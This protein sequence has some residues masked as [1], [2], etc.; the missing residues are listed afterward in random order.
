MRTATSMILACLL[1]TGCSMTARSV[2]DEGAH[3][4]SDETIAQQRQ[5]LAANTAGRGFGPQSPRDIDA[6]SGSNEIAFEAAPPPSRMN[7]C[8]IHFHQN[9]EHRGGEF[10]LY[11]GNGDGH[12]YGSGY[13]YSGTLT[14][15]ELQPTG[16]D[17]CP[18]KHGA[19]HP[20]DTIEAHYVYSSAY[21]RPGPSL[22]S[23]MSDSIHNPQLR[24]EAQVFVL[25]NDESAADFRELAGIGETNGLQQALHLPMNTGAPVEYAGSTTGPDYDEVGSPLQVSWSVRPRV[26]KVNAETIGEWCEHNVF[27]EDHAHGV[28]NLVLNPAL[29]SPIPVH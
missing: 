16:H 26:M 13:R 2:H 12:G 18:G 25:V 14:E 24:V 15:A 19:L 29:L 22:K 7:L 9:A 8:N 28:R 1:S 3:T 27:D 21:V 20:G 11:A 4:A 17:I 23:C 6:R 10:L 5:A